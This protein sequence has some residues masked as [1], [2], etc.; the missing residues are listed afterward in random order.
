[1][2]AISGKPERSASRIGSGVASAPDAP[3]KAAWAV[4]AVATLGMSVSYIDRQT[5]AAIAPAVTKAL[6]IDNT[7][8]GWLL[9]AFS[10]SYLVGAP[11]AGILV[12][13][14]GARRG[15]AGAVL[16]WSIIA[17]AHALS[18][19]FASLFVLRVLLG[20]AEAPS[21]PAA[22][23]AIRRVLPGAR[24][25]LAFGLLFTGSSLGAIVAAKLA[26]R[27]EAEY[28]F[29][30][31]FVGT[32]LIGALWLPIWLLVT[33]GQG[34]DRT[35]PTAPVAIG[36]PPA[37]WWTV[38]TSAPVLR[39]IVAIAGCAPLLMFVLNWT[40]KYLVDTWKMPKEGVGNYL[41]A[42]PLLF[43]LGAV[44]FGAIASSRSAR[45]GTRDASELRPNAT[46][47]D[48][49]HRDLLLAS[50]L[51]AA[52]LALV[53]FASSPL[54]AI[55]LFATAACGGGGLYAL[56]TADML[57]RVPV[58]RTSSAGGMTA[59]AQSLSH[60]VAG[61]LIGWTIDRTHSYD[62]AVVLL[63]VSVIP[64]MLAFL[65]WPGVRRS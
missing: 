40:S 24:R 38:M 29:R 37:A 34:L 10:L 53:P 45:A 58:E 62:I 65:A 28:G 64:T 13:R 56:V 17:G 23:Q 14:L 48:V 22:T 44:G 42:A 21:F 19:S 2:D 3:S 11:L 41:I 39:A 36:A 47:G 57:G 61:P 50:M 25:P 59:A 55:A 26:V 1:M 35:G 54:S 30:A 12:D 46:R 52:T 6:S 8:Y 15:F 16:V 31:A 63:G 9:S 7:Q 4:A 18:A 32:A 60:V 49:T 5:L 43:D 27:L 33:R 20:T 51:L